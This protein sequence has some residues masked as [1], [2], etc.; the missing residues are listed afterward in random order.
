M[1]PGKNVSTSFGL[2]GI[3]MSEPSTARTLKSSSFQYL[4]HRPLKA[5]ITIFKASGFSFSRCWIKA[6]EVAVLGEYPSISSNSCFIEFPPI[7]TIH[8]IT[9]KSGSLRL[10]VKCR[11]GSTAI[12]IGDI[13]TFLMHDNNSVF[14]LLS[15]M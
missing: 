2:V 13:L 14:N 12:S 15:F 5:S 9:S 4:L 7:A 10:R 3:W 11:S 8:L 6:E 1:L